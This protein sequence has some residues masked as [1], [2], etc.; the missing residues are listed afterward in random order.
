MTKHKY[1]GA[2]RGN[3]EK[4]RGSGN[5]QYL[6]QH[7]CAP[8]CHTA[9]TLSLPLC[10]VSVKAG[11]QTALDWDPL[12]A[13]GHLTPSLPFGPALSTWKPLATHFC[14][15]LQ[16]RGVF[17]PCQMQSWRTVFAGWCFAEATERQQINYAHHYKTNQPN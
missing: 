16:C 15:K 7:A 10:K 1:S 13:R 17:H 9:R 8:L 11:L 5:P 4:L 12:S 2:S 14:L 6:D 3:C